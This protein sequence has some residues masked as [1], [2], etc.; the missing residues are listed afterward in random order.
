M[1]QLLA[2][3]ILGLSCSGAVL[4][5][6]LPLLFE[7][8]TGYVELLLAAGSAGSFAVFA[9]SALVFRNRLNHSKD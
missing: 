4:M 8:P 7:S 6:S 1:N 2:F 5:L 9:A 3:S